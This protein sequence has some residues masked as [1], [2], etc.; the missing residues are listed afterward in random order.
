MNKNI[1]VS[2]L[3]TGIPIALGYFAVAFALGITCGNVGINPLQAGIMSWCML[4]SAGEYSAV[5]L[6]AAG[7]GALEMITTT[8]IVNLR[9][10]L[11]GA[12][13]SQKVDHKISMVHRF[14][15]SYCITD[16]I[17]AVCSSVDGKLNPWYAYGVT[18]ISAIGWTAGTVL[19]VVMG[20]I[21]PA[22]LVAA[23]SVALYGMFL[24]V[25]IPASK[26]DHFIGILVIISM[27]ASLIFTMAP[28][29]SSISF[30]FRVII[31][32]LLIAGAAAVIRPVDEDD[33]AN[34]D[35]KANAEAALNGTADAA[36]NSGA[37]GGAAK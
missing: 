21:L 30:G 17:F 15:L 4:A 10:F 33:E 9:Y 36:V 29:L 12:A 6:I 31:L 14:L 24:A 8:V 23:L 25:I 20:N 7:A 1:F 34:A 11:M 27:T 26:K 3:R 32:T 13:L 16:E 18:F 37:E 5:S 28:V 2:G 19:G 22:R 35:T